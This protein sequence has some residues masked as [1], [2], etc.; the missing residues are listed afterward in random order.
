MLTKKRIPLLIALICCIEIIIYAWAVWTA[1]LDRSNFF[2]I[3]SKFIFAKAAR[4]SGRVSAAI[5]LITLLMVGYYGLKEIYRE[6]KKKD[7]FQILISLFLVNHLIHFVFLYL[8]FQT[9]SKPLITDGNARGIVTFIFIVLAPFI[10]WTYKSLN[11]LLYFAIILHLFNVSYFM[12]I[13]FLSKIKPADPAYHD[14]FGIVA[15]IAALLYILY[16]VFQEN[17]PNS[18]AVRVQ[19]MYA[20]GF[21]LFSLFL[22]GYFIL[23]VFYV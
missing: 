22:I 14:Q 6:E 1:T 21:T 19:C 11:K 5:F 13:T 12:N 20:G 17:K 2:A 7:A 10:L 15:L 4:N 3:E 18:P 23:R 16:R 9:H 8:N